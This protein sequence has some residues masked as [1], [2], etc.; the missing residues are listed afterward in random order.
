MIKRL[1]IGLVLI[2]GFLAFVSA[3]AA[4]V[5]LIAYGNVRLW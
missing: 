2:L 1:A 4:M 5:Q 3:L